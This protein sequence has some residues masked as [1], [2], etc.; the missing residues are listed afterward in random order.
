MLRTGYCH[1]QARD[2]Y[3]TLLWQNDGNYT[4]IG[5]TKVKVSLVW[6][7]SRKTKKGGNR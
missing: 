7:L 1:Y 6:L 5:P 3:K 4:W 2:N